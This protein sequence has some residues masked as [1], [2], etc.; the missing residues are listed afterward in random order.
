MIL[1]YDVLAW[2]VFV[3]WD[4]FVRV[5]PFETQIGRKMGS[6]TQDPVVT[7]SAYLGVNTQSLD[8]IDF[9]NVF[10]LVSHHCRSSMIIPIYVCVRNV[11]L[12]RCF[13]FHN[14]ECEVG[15]SFQLNSIFSVV[16]LKGPGFTRHRV[17]FYH[18]EL[19][20]VSLY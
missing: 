5:F 11:Q 1:L 10:S 17:V 14:D 3:K 16:A 2:F 15:V 4:Q 18:I 6:D 7:E 19:R 8:K 20:P 9:A 13:Y 12:L